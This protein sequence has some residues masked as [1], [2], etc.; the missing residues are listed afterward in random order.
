MANRDTRA[1]QQAGNDDSMMVPD[2]GPEAAVLAPT[3]AF[4]ARPRQYA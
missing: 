2:D 3:L 4:P 1:E